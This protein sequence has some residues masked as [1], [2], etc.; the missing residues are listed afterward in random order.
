MSDVTLPAAARGHLRALYGEERGAVL[1]ALLED[2]AGAFRA[3]HPHPATPPAARLSEDDVFLIAYPDQVHAPGEAPLASLGRLLRGPLARTVSGVH[4]LPF[5]PWS[6]DDG[7]SVVD[8]GSVDPNV[9]GW[10]DIADLARTHRLMFDAVIN[11]VSAKSAYLQGFLTGDP[12]YRGFFLE[13][14]PE[15]DLRAVVRP[16][17]TPLATT[18]QGADG[19]RHDL[20]TTFSTDQVDLDY[21]TPEVLLE[22]ARV[23]LQYVARGAQLLRLDAVTF[24]WKEPGTTC[25]S[26]PQTHAVLKVLRALLEAAAPWVVMLTETNVPHGENVGYFGNGADEAQMVYNFALPPLVLHSVLSGDAA[27][28]RGWAADLTTPSE[29]TCFFNF[30][31]SHDGIGLRA[32]EGILD[33]DALEAV[34][35]AVRSRGGHVSSR[36]TAHGERPYELNINLF[37]ALTPPGEA[38]GDS[39]RRFATAH[40]VMLALAGV[41][42]LYAHSLL[43]SR[44]APAEVERT[45]RARSINREKLDLGVL[46][47]ELADAQGRRTRILEALR[48]LL[49]VRRAH[50]AFAPGAA[51]Q[52]LPTEAGVFGVRREAA[53]RAVWCLHN[54]SNVPAAVPGAARPRRGRD[55]L[56]GRVLEPSEALTL[57]PRQTL[58]LEEHRET[59]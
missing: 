2:E 18:F 39:V 53:G 36:A 33:D 37:D 26:L 32:A 28:L 29:T 34:V 10:E 30:L 58:W 40:A 24:L 35:G 5:Y 19:R 9:G 20:W 14:T 31:A 50:P 21:R 6:S 8:Y 15:M 23:L 7:F 17:T 22:V 47:A 43:G 11:H 45:G 25:A 42:A 52:V 3:A 54:L 12:R 59:P 55:L 46:E 4:L 27:A 48:A 57:E 13:V 38:L 16:R 56:E 41:P 44:G 49:Q 51:Q 1:A